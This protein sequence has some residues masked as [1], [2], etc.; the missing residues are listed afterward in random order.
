MGSASADAGGKFLD[1]KSDVTKASDHLPSLTNILLVEDETPDADRLKAMLHL[2]FGYD[3]SVRR[4][5]TLNSAMDAVLA[6]MP[7]LIFL[8]DIL[9]PSDTATQSIPFLRRAGYDGPIVV[10]SGQ[11]TRTRISELKTTGAADVLHKDDVNSVRVR[12]CLAH[13][14]GVKLTAPRTASAD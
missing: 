7:D 11:A 9:K 10:I 6:D 5:A 4:A 1:R 12:E 2:M 13:L 3:I 8:D 14:Y